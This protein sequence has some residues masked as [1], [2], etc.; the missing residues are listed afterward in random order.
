MSLLDA[1]QWLDRRLNKK[2][3]LYA[4]MVQYEIGEATEYRLINAGPFGLFP[5]LL[6]NDACHGKTTDQ[7]NHFRRKRYRRG[8]PR[9]HCGK[10][11]RMPGNRRGET[12]SPGAGQSHLVAK[13]EAVR[14]FRK[15]PGHRPRS[16][17]NGGS[18]EQHSCRHSY[19]SH[20]RARTNHNHPASTVRARN[21]LRRKAGALPR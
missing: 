8:H 20:V 19:C 18:H 15:E 5:T 14:K 6:I 10:R 7:E 9:V 17:P 12:R 1:Q 2:W 13:C 16:Q 21:T 3:P 11:H 4:V